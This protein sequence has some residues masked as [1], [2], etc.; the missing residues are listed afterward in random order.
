VKNERRSLLAFFSQKRERKQSKSEKTTQKVVIFSVNHEEK[1]QFLRFFW[2]FRMLNV[3]R[4]SQGYSWGSLPHLVR[5]Q[6]ALVWVAAFLMVIAS[7]PWALG[8]TG[9][10]T[11]TRI[12]PTPFVEETTIRMRQS[13]VP[14][15]L[16]P[17]FT[18]RPPQTWLSQWNT[19]AYGSFR[20]TDVEFIEPDSGTSTPRYEVSR[21]RGAFNLVFDWVEGY[22]PG[23]YEARITVKSG[24]KTETLTQI[25]HWGVVAVNTRTS[26]APTGTNRELHFAVLDDFGRTECDSAIIATITDPRGRKTSLSTVSGSIRKNPACADRSVTNAPDYRALLSPTRNGEY[27]ISVSATT[28]NGVRTITD[29][30]SV[31][32][33]PLFDVERVEFPTRI[34]P[35]AHY[36]VVFRVT[37]QEDFSGTITETVPAS[38]AV[39]D[40][41]NGGVAV[42]GDTT[43]TTQRIAWNV[44]WKQNET[45]TL[46][47]TFKA[48]DISPLLHRLGPLTFLRTDG[49]TAFQESRRWQMAADATKTWDGGGSTASWSECANWDADACPAATGDAI[50]FDGTSNDNSD[51]DSGSSVTSIASI[52]VSSMS[53]SLTFTKTP[54]TI[55]GAFSHTSTGNVIFASSVAISVGGDFTLTTSGSLTQNTSSL[56]MTGTS[57]NF[58]SAKTFYDVTINPSSTGTIS[59]ATNDPTISNL[60]TVSSGDTMTINSGR[61]VTL[62]CASCTALTLDGTINDTSN[63]G[64]LT[65]QTSTQFPTGGTMN[66]ILR[67]DTSGSSRTAPGRT[68]GGD[69]EAF[70]SSSSIRVLTMGSGATWNLSRNL[71]IMANGTQTLSFN[72]NT[73]NPTVNLTGDLDYTGTG[74]GNE[75]LTLGTNQWTVSGSINLEGSTGSFSGNGLIVM[76]GTSKNLQANSKTIPN[77]QVSGTITVT[78]TDVTVSTALTVDSNKTLTI[79]TSRTASLGS[80]ASLTL[81]GTITG[82]GTLSYSPS[83]AFPTSGTFTTNLKLPN[84]TT[85]GAR[86]SPNGYGGNVDANCSSILDPAPDYTVTLGTAGSQ[87]IDITGNL[88]LAMSGCTMTVTGASNNPTVNIGGNISYSTASTTIVTGSGTWTV[89]GSVTLTNGTFTASSGNTLVMNGTSKTLTSASQTLQNL[90]LSGS[91]TLANATHTVAGNL[92]MAGG[93]IT[94]GTSTVTMTGTSNTITG[95]GA[96]LNNLTIDPA[97]AGT[98]TLQ[99]SNLTV[100]ATLSVASGDALSIDASRTLTSGTSGTVTITGTISGSGTLTVKNSNLGTGGTLSSA[101]RFDTTSGD[102][103]MPARTY[104]GNVEIYDNGGGGTV[105]MGTAGSQTITIQGS[106]N[107][108][109]TEI[110][111]VGLGGDTYNPTVNI[112]GN[113]TTEAGGW[114]SITSGTGVWTVTGN[115]DSYE[116]VATSGNELI[117]NGTAFINANGSLFYKLT[118]NGT[119]NTVTATGTDTV[120]NVLTIGGA[121]DGNNDTLLIDTGC[122]L[123]SGT[124]GTV[125]LVGSGTD[126]ITANGTGMLRVRNSNLGTLGTISA[127]V[128]FYNANVTMPART[129]GGDVEASTAA[130]S[131]TVT[132]GSG[133]HTISGNLS[134]ASTGAGNMALTGATN[135]PTVALTGNISM[136]KSSTG[137]PSIT[138]GANSW[139]VSGNVNF[140]NGTYT[141]TAGNTLIMNGTSKALTSNAQTLGN[142]QV[143]GGSISNADAMD[144]NGTFTVSAGSFT[145]AG[146]VNIN[147]SGNVSLSNGT[148]VAG[149]TGAGKIILDG[150]LSLTDSNTTKQ[151]L[152]NVQVGTSPDTTNLGSD[153][154][155]SSLTVAAGDF[156]YTNGYDID[157]S[158]DISISG[159]FDATDDVETDETDINCAGNFSIN[160]G[161]TFVQDQSTLTMDATSGTKDIVTDGSF[162]LYNLVLSDGGG[163]LTVEVEDALDVDKNV[164]ITGGTLDAKS[165]ESNQINVGGAWDNDAYFTRQQGLVVFDAT[166]GTKTIDAEGDSAPGSSFYDITFNDGGGSA[167]W[168]LTTAMDV[169]NNLTITGG[170]FNAN[171]NNITIA[172]NF[173]NDDAFTSGTQTTTFD[174]TTGTKTI[175]ADGTGAEAFSSVIFNDGGGSAT[176]QLTTTMD[177]NADLTITGGNFNANSNAITVGGNWDND[178]TFTSG[179][180]TTTFDATTGTKTIDADGTGAEAFSSVI[181][182]DGG[183]SAVWQLTTAMDVEGNLTITG[184]NFNANSNNISAAG[185]WDNNDTFTSGTQTVTFDGG[186]NNFTIEA[187]ASTFSAVDFNSAGSLARWTIQTNDLTTTG[188]L[189]F[190]AGQISVQAARTIEVQGNFSLVESGAGMSWGSGTTLY[191]NGSGGMYDI[192]SKTHG[193]E[194]YVTLRVGASEDIAMWDSSATTYTIDPG[195]CLF[196]EDHG[197]TAGRMNIY[198]VCY[199]RSNEYWSYATDFDG[200]ALGG[201]SRQ[202]DVRLAED[203]ELIVENGDTLAIIGQ[204]AVANRTLVSRISSGNYGLTIQGTINAQYYDIDYASKYGLNITATATV[205]ELSNGSFDNCG[206]GGGASYITVAGIT[207]TDT[208]QDNIFDDESDEQDPNVVYNVNADGAGIN[209][210]FQNY[211]GNKGGEAYDYETNGA[212][213]TW[214]A[215]PAIE[216][217]ISDNSMDLGVVSPS[218][219][220]SDS[221][222]ITLTTT[223][224]SGY[225]CKVVEDDNL[226]NGANVITDVGDGTVTAG[227]EEYG[228]SCSSGGCQLSG[229]NGI[230]GSPLTVSSSVGPVTSEETTFTYK[231]SVNS[232]T[233]ALGYSHI[234]TYTCT[235][236]F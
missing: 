22:H 45:Q 73:N 60:L 36:P 197:G 171:S 19:A 63:N 180:Q 215:P 156:L 168:Q 189:A 49:S 151:D 165:G 34:Y 198:G 126:S 157:S 41:S 128:Q 112:V 218:A 203:S 144:V 217:T 51:W 141:A 170:N 88:T 70:S 110:N 4:L 85:L 202:A 90:T 39:R 147:I 159:T 87:T 233:D 48:P 132:M 172:G 84:S 173:D 11:L 200:A 182:N 33:E 9:G 139:T 135:A 121:A 38:F 227:S 106:L 129:Y 15:G 72:G 209:W 122:I 130:T 29:T 40:V 5:V 118:I 100:S 119:N 219:V 74:S 16:S 223:A 191:L 58:N 10:K 196:S 232:T 89:T 86:T 183:G 235:G 190:T 166:T 116:Y 64:R 234:V 161:A 195:G 162:S 107:L 193:G 120:T 140:T 14:A 133:T 17:Q 44:S 57:N 2:Y 82:A 146:A 228:L 65:Y 127:K 205:T 21:T 61:T 194:T 174:A 153:I 8:I 7:M 81:N 24:G 92:S 30:F 154:K 221:H 178:D 224:A 59:I 103:S 109:G 32:D 18:I 66:A 53:G 56:T 226:R 12:L 208:F 186:E 137:T 206:A 211:W 35:P 192:N 43:S 13:V 95:G 6:E 212:T 230:S 42:T 91:I 37:P 55:T 214:S 148:T 68:Y 216:F 62:S 25:F 179:T 167:E 28:K 20:V 213:V 169:N 184:G 188:N 23:R 97:S 31:A 104:G 76:N 220:N 134:V 96:T 67:Y 27:R 94:A 160:S 142:Y 150:D 105:T 80:S 78:G 125:T 83:T 138:S 136:S 77:V 229:D 176:F 152:G 225:T 111:G 47:Y 236:N 113:V 143:S 117:M 231:A 187:G 131:R 26:I 204:S 50:V 108:N 114:G 79:D 124:S 71:Y 54:V 101:V 75:A 185:S 145:A 177:V 163:S 158:G 199:S 181:F 98:I 123:T 210:T 3:L 207:S 99:T 155:V 52:T 1:R 222:T 115:F 175:D 164:T 102:I 46:A 201:S 69:F 149:P 93:T